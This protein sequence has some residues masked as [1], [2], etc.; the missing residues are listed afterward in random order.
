METKLQAHR[1][2]KIRIRIGFGSVFVVDGIGKSRGLAL[3]WT[4][5]VRVD[6]QNYSRRHINAV[7]K[8]DGVAQGWKFTGFY[9]HPEVLKRKESWTLLRHLSSYQSSAWLSMGDYNE[10]SSDEEKFGVRRQPRR[11]MND[12]RDAIEGSRLVDLGFVGPKFTWSNSQLVGHFTMERLD[13]ALANEEWKE[14][15][16]FRRVEVL[17]ACASDHAPVMISF[18]KNASQRRKKKFIFGYE[19]AWHKCTTYKEVIKKVCRVKENNRGAWYSVLN[20]LEKCKNSLIQWKKE[21][22][23]QSEDILKQTTTKLLELQGEEE[24]WDLDEIKN[25]QSMANGLLEEEEMKWQ[26][27]A[28]VDWLKHGDKNSKYF[29]A[30]ATQRRRAN[31]ISSIIDAEGITC[32]SPESVV[33]AFLS[34]FRWVLSTSSPTG[35]EEA[36]AVVPRRITNQMNVDLEREISIEEVSLALSQMTPLKST[37][38]DGFPVGFFQDNW[39]VVALQYFFSS[40]VIFPTINSTF[41]ALVPKKSNPYVVSDFRPISL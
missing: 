32:D 19:V 2:E 30:C 16:P 1:I 29:H 36:L 26:Q 28:K 39:V 12:F 41:I 3:F 25:L 21:N 33:E 27:R 5:E 7:V 13:R 6:I 10:I 38:P 37:G 35:V 22:K 14:L 31:K 18:H 4:T 9:G 11:Q 17:A 20:K 8:E 40:G 15:Y 34:Y 24:E 23:S